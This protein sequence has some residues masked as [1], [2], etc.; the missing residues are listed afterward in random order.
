MQNLEERE[1]TKRE[2]LERE[3]KMHADNAKMWEDKWHNHPQVVVQR[4]E[5]GGGG[6]GRR[7]NI[8]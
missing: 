2:F 4:V 3:L 7:C 1:A 6:G 5:T 8:F